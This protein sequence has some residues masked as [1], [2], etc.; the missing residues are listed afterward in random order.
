MLH[1]ELFSTNKKIESH[2]VLS[3]VHLSSN[4]DLGV[5]S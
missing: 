3:S 1:E 5:V 2:V 4:I